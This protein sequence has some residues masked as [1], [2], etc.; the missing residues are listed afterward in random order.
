MGYTSYPGVLGRGEEE[1]RLAHTVCKWVQSRYVSEY[2]CNRPCNADVTANRLRSRNYECGSFT[3]AYHLLR[4]LSMR[5]RCR[6]S[7]PERLGTRIGCTLSYSCWKGST[8]FTSI[9]AVTS[10]IGHMRVRPSMRSRAHKDH[11]RALILL[12]RMYICT[13]PRTNRSRRAGNEYEVNKHTH[14][15]GKVFINIRLNPDDSL[16]FSVVVS[17]LFC[18]HH[19]S[20]LFHSDISVHVPTRDVLIHDFWR[21]SVV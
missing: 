17:G 11:E 3:R 16:Y 21:K 9:S 13:A 10:R 20:S 14:K 12:S 2:T 15:G 7:S 5:K 18:F 6:S 4:H 8:T 1:K 19:S